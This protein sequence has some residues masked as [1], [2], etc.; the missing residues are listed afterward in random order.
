MRYLW[1]ALIALVL[2]PV[3]ALAG[4]FI[5]YWIAP[6]PAFNLLPETHYQVDRELVAAIYGMPFIGGFL[7]SHPY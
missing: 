1:F 7:Y 4:Y 2:L 5:M 6:I 3:C